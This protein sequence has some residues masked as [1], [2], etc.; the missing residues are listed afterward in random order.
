MHLSQLFLSNVLNTSSQP[1]KYSQFDLDSDLAASDLRSFQ[2]SFGFKL[3][4]IDLLHSI[5]K[6]Q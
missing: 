1:A 2:C 4:V 6:I 5:L 3:S